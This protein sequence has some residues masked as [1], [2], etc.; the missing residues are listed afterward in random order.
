MH[1]CGGK[2]ACGHAP[3]WGQGAHN[4]RERMTQSRACADTGAQWGRVKSSSMTAA[5]T[6]RAAPLGM[7]GLSKNSA[8]GPAVG[9]SPVL[10][11]AFSAPQAG[12]H[13]R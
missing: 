2:G 3:L 7:R 12:R 6:K 13:E 1:H 5:D 9:S 4:A 11:T 10:S 8:S